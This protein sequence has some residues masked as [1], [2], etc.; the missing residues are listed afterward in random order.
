[1]SGIPKAA[2]IPLD[3]IETVVSDRGGRLMLTTTDCGG[4]PQ[5]GDR[6]TSIHLVITGPRRALLEAETIETKGNP[7]WGANAD[8]I[9]VTYRFKPLG[10]HQNF[11]VTKTLPQLEG[12]PSVWQYGRG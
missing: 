11:E 8:A 4:E 1:M 3:Q 6:G 10:Y 7:E 9:E 5:D 2:S 12:H